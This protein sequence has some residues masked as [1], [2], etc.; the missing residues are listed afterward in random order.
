MNDT[1][2]KSEQT[3]ESWKEIAA[4]LQRQV[5]TVRRWETE[6]G[7]PV[8]RHSHK[9]RASVYA[10]PSEI[11]AWREA[12][13]VL[14]APPPP[15]PLWKVL[16]GTRRSWAFGVT[17][18]LCLVMV[19]NGLRPQIAEAQT[20]QTARQVWAGGADEVN[21]QGS[22][23]ADGRWLSFTE[24]KRGDLAIRN[25]ATGEVRRL[26]SNTDEEW[27][28]F[29]EDSI[30]STD[31]RRAVYAWYTLSSNS[32]DLR[33][34]ST[35]GVAQEPRIIYRNPDQ[36]YMQPVGWLRDGS[37]LT[38]NTARDRTHQIASVRA[39]G[40]GATVLKSFDWRS[41]NK[42]SV[43]PDERFVAYDFAP[44]E[45]S[46]AHD[47]YVL[48]VDGSRE[49]RAVQSPADDLLLG[50]APDGK[51]L[52]FVSDRTGGASLYAIAME[53]GKPSGQAEL[54]KRDTGLIR[55]LGV[56]ANGTLVYSKMEGI[57][58]IYTVA[59]DP[60][61]LRAVAKPALVAQRFQGL[62]EGADWSPDGKYLAYA[63][64]RGLTW[65]SPS[66][67]TIHSMAD[68]SE[69]DVV[70]KLAQ[71]SGYRGVRWWPDGRSIVVRGTDR[72]GNDGAFRIDVE[73]GD[74]VELYRGMLPARFDWGAD[75]RTLYFRTADGEKSGLVALNTQDGTIRRLE[76]TRESG[77]D[78]AVS[79]DGKTMVYAGPAKKGA[80]LIIMSTEGGP[81]RKLLEGFQIAYAL[82][83]WSPDGE[84]LLFGKPGAELW[85]VNV[86]T[87]EQAFV[88]K[89]PKEEG[90]IAVIRISPDGKTM[91]YT[92]GAPVPE[93]WTLENF[94]APPAN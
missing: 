80:D 8:H 94:L 77:G 83:A 11:D 71:I 14:S 33:T 63:S 50:W 25:L 74:T 65:D 38:Y 13:K 68:G 32:Y 48:A 88:G 64:K 62:N 49:L 51:T 24:Q 42:L 52:L 73:S 85:R 69:R 78:F 2:T 1:P 4:Y 60:K 91:S 26:T 76:G 70:T 41:S 44:S 28:T 45:E 56:S 79:P 22:I 20:K 37:V 57:R 90:R 29:A 19:G 67:L 35:V 17:M 72:K 40:R 34:V 9:A 21:I 12:R 86:K 18:A 47:I 6:E 3:L 53:D 10:Y 93:V 15:R 16:F 75:R 39:D 55:A 31:G 23:S 61:T 43:S 82:L 5:R 89:Y 36:R 7:L 46:P 59:I 30:L 54:V 84:T 27:K 58:D 66:V 87:G 92:N 81:Q